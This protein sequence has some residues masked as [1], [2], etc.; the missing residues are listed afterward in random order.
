MPGSREVLGIKEKTKA[1]WHE[2]ALC[3][4]DRLLK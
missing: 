3:R 1:L 4:W 2:D